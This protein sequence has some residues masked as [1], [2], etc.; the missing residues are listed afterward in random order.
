MN[1]SSEL[2]TLLWM[3]ESIVQYRGTDRSRETERARRFSCVLDAHALHRYRA[4]PET[5]EKMLTAETRESQ[6]DYEGGWRDS[7]EEELSSLLTE[8]F[9]F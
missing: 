1:F 8:S 9:L 6:S 3:T 2:Y 4:T 7:R 5:D